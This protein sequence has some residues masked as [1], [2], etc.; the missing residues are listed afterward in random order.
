MSLPPSEFGDSPFLAIPRDE[1]IADNG[2]GFAIFDRYPV[3][4]GHTLVIP[5][6]PFVT[7]WD[8][9]EATQVGLM[10][11]VGVVKDIL[12]ARYQ[13]DGY[14]VGFNAGP[15]AGQ[16]VGHLHLH[17][18]PRRNNDVA[19]PRGGVRHVIPGKGNYLS[20]EVHPLPLERN[21]NSGLLLDAQ[22]TQGQLRS[23]LVRCLQS[24]EYD[25]IDI[26]VSFI[27][28]SGLDLILS[29]LADTLSRNARVRIL[30]T[31]Y[32]EVTDPD[33]LTSLLD[34]QSSS[35]P[36]SDP[37]TRGN[38]R[39]SG[40]GTLE[41]KVWSQPGRSFHPKAYLFHSSSGPRAEAFVGSSNLSR[42][43]IAGGIE[44]NLS[45]GQTGELLPSFEAMWADRQAVP[46][47][48]EFVHQYRQI[49]T[50]RLSMAPD[51]IQ[52]PEIE[53]DPPLPVARPTGIQ[54]EA[55]EALAAT[56]RAGYPSGLVVMATGLGKT[57]LAAFD[58]AREEFERILF[59][60]HREEIL[61]QSRDV[62]RRVHPEATMG[63]FYGDEKQRD[64]RMVFASI[65][66]LGQRLDEFTPDEFDYIVI[67]EFHHA[68]APSYRDVIDFFTP[69]FL[70][71]LTATPDRLDGADLLPLCGD[72]IVFECDVVEGINRQQL[73]PF[74]YQGHKDV[75]DFSEIPWRQRRFDPQALTQALETR[76]R[77]QQSLDIWRSAGNGSR[78]PGPTLGFCCS[79]THAEYLARFFTEAG[80]PSVAVHSGPASAP[81]TGS[82]ERLR[83]GDIRI[84]FTV[85]VFNEGVDIPEVTTVM[86]LRPTESPV[87]FLQ[88][89]GRGLRRA[90]DKEYLEV[91]DFI[92]NHRSFLA[93]PRL[94]LGLGTAARLSDKQV[95]KALQLG[96]F[97][98][99]EG[100][101]VDYDLE[102]IDLLEV[103]ARTS[104]RTGARN[105]L[106]DFCQEY[107]DAN[108]HRPSALQA[109]RAGY[110]PK[111]ATT[112]GGPGWFGLLAELGLLTDDEIAVVDH[113]A[114]VLLRFEKESVTRSYKLVTIQALLKAGELRRSSSIAS[115]A[116][117]SRAMILRDP[118]LVA[119]VASNEIPDIEAVPDDV[120]VRYW[121]K[122][123]LDHLASGHKRALFRLTGDRFGPTFTIDDLHGAAFDSMV[124]ELMAWRL[125][126][127]LLRNPVVPDQPETF[128]LSVSHANGNPILR[129]DRRRQPGLPEGWT[130]VDVDD[131]PLEI[132]FV[133][134]AANVA[135]REGS[136]GN[137]LHALIRGWFGPDA[138]RPGT[139]QR[140]VLQK[141]G[142]RWTLRPDLA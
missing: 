99:P 51:R 92:G 52:P 64:A 17:L 62:F 10:Q 3:V 111:S 119:D 121:R 71:G 69:R 20:H 117:T 86:M 46:L 125:A 142:A 84:I 2:F 113:H 98:L 105:V 104:G 31:D 109:L 6:R 140:V 63:L 56:R 88:Q 76:D 11:L 15:A 53:L 123:P 128:V 122:W 40:T 87:V 72:N 75:A 65:Q 107:A 83:D 36:R 34:L 1:W 21:P 103:L 9:D 66:T 112:N 74:H 108:G 25:R 50:E 48:N 127:Y 141:T 33:A 22:T 90:P 110:N 120:W 137:A 114:D 81:R 73:V 23:H 61:T 29:H 39:P 47:T 70:L 49:R 7:W 132:N 18:I 135:R 16:T 80:V 91:I 27:M 5:H 85:D 95:V 89:L 38:D 136:E 57:W 14:N 28:R 13:P 93:K 8:A 133:T 124:S 116:A 102:S 118:R 131:Q 58:S 24:P 37:S 115:I 101:S 44:W 139:K 41:V 126:D 55:L 138:G 45:I 129:F 19:D 68:A 60:A 42:S 106:G 79:I 32:L 54:S 4:P 78:D 59:I 94:L 100:C 77:A 35:V 67:D 134:I 82:V 43:G 97:D 96:G 30:T 12:D 130:P 26:V